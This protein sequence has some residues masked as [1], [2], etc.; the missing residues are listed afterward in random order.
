VV[1][2]GGGSV[3]VD[4]NSASGYCCTIGG[5]RRNTASISFAT[6]GGGELNSASN[7]YATVGGGHSNK[8]RGSYSV[9]AGGGGDQPSDSNSASGPWSTIGGGRGNTAS[10]GNATVGGGW[11]NTASGGGATVPGGFYNTA[12]GYY[13]FAA[14]QRAKANHDGAFVWADGIG[15]DFIST[16]SN[17]FLIRAGG[18]VGVGTNNP[19]AQL[20][21]A[22]QIRSSSGGFRFPDGSLQTTAAGAGSSYWAVSGSNIYNSNS[23][24][25]GIGTTTPGYKLHIEGQ[26]ISGIG[27]SASGQYSTVGGGWTNSAS[28]WYS[29]VS[30]GN[31]NTAGNVGSTVSG[32]NGNSASGYDGTVGGGVNN[33]ASGGYATVGG[34]ANNAASAGCAVVAGGCTV[35]AEGENSSV[36]GGS[37]NIAHG[38]GST[39][40]GGIDNLAEG[41]YTVAMGRQAKAGHDGSFVWADGS[42]QDFSTTA[43]NQFL[44]RAQGG[45]G[46]GTAN[47][48]RP[49]DVAGNIRAS[50]NME[51]VALNQVS[52]LRLKTDIQPICDALSKI[53]LLQ[54]VS[55]RWNQNAKSVGATPGDQQIGVIAQDVE[56]VFPELVSTTNNGYKSVDYTKLTAVLLE[57]IKELKAQNEKQQAEIENLKAERK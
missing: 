20:D 50:G 3:I 44:I 28:D 19:Q 49:L 45:V 53:E 9:V 52:D 48:Q 18:G 16:A 42:G 47:P 31:H 24:N 5:G 33:G 10:G 25:V 35:R 30:G 21:V 41:D 8:A 13:S 39:I 37:N 12:Q 17:Q 14:G 56:Q 4:S 51:C 43:N 15:Q 23:G 46:I 1:A 7:A 54:G 2:G 11:L 36:G 38:L 57:A 34:G 6:V 27:S 26:A 40:P 22:G 32:G 55:F 29:T